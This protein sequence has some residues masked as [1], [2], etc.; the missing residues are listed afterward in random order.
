[1]GGG[2]VCKNPFP[3]TEAGSHLN[4]RSPALHLLSVVETGFAW[5][6][7]ADPTLETGTGVYSAF[8]ALSWEGGSVTAQA[9]DQCSGQRWQ[10]R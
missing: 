4:V 8:T 9:C 10:T 6:R 2:S 3:S 7:E 1:M 5:S